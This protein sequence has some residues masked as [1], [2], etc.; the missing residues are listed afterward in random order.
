MNAMAQEE[1]IVPKEFLPLISMSKVKIKVFC[2]MVLHDRYMIEKFVG[3]GDNTGLLKSFSP[4]SD[5][6]G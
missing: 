6:A 1:I 4:K 2:V 5:C 3:K